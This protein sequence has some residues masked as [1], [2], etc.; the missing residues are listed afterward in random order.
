MPCG[1]YPLWACDCLPRD[2]FRDNSSEYLSASQARIGRINFRIDLSPVSFSVSEVM[3]MLASSRMA[4]ARRQSNMLRA[5][6]EN[7][8]TYI[9]SM[10]LRT[11][12]PFVDPS[13]W[14]SAR[15]IRAW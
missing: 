2:T 10:R 7:A 5:M 14:T 15:L 1:Q 8:H 9:R 13:R 4:I 6:R 3:S 12:R 11:I